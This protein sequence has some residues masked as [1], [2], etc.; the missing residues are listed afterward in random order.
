[1]AVAA[2]AQECLDG[3][4]AVDEL[5]D[6]GELSEREASEP[7]VRGAVAGAEQVFDFVEAEADPLGGVDD[8]E[9][10]QDRGLVAAF[11]SVAFGRVDQAASFVVAHA[12]GAH[13]GLGGELA[14]REPVTCVWHP[15]TWP[16]T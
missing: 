14:D 15:R 10:A 3:G 2:E 12:A 4:G 11:A 7:F 6:F 13:P 16:L 1:M 5:L 8:R 9:A